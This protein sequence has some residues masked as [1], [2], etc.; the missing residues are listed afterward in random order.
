MNYAR[1]ICLSVR[2]LESGAR[3]HFWINELCPSSLSFPPGNILVQHPHF[4]KKA[5][6]SEPEPATSSSDDIVLGS[7]NLHT[8]Q[9]T[10]GRLHVHGEGEKGTPAGP[11]HPG[12]MPVTPPCK[13]SEPI[14]ALPD[15]IQQQSRSDAGIGQGGG[16]SAA[17][18]GMTLPC[19]AQGTSSAADGKT[20]FSSKTHSRSGSNTSQQSFASMTES[21]SSRASPQHGPP[22]SFSHSSSPS[23][24]GA[25]AVSQSL[26]DLQDPTKFTIGKGEQKKRISKASFDSKGSGAGMEIKPDPADPLSSLDAMWSIHKPEQSEK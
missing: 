17:G 14:S 6:I 25:G 21:G 20:E 9:Q 5:K 12:Q 2:C 11:D 13:E 8:L 4:E 19:T 10:V 3:H 16:G 22:S 15:L 7:V 1:H 24:G 26:A 18:S 23:A